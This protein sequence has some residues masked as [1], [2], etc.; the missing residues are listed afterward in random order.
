MNDHSHA[1]NG[2]S[3]AAP[4]VV[5]LTRGAMTESRHRVAAA[6]ADASGAVLLAA[7]DPERPIYARS[8]IKPLQA[9]AMVETG[10]TEAFGLGDAEIALACA[11][12]SGEPAHV[13]TVRAWLARIGRGEEDLECGA[14]PPLHLDSADSLVQSGTGPSPMH[15]NCSGKHCGFL[16]AAHHLGYDSKGYVGYQHPV[17]Q[18]VLGILEQMTGLDLGAAPRGTDGC[19]IPVIGIPLGNVALAMAR[20]ADPSDQPDHRQEAAARI[21]SAMIAE[22]HM[23]AGTGR[24]DTRV[25]RAMDGKAVVKGGAEGVHCAA[26]PGAGVGICVKAEDGAKR[27]AEAV[28]AH[29]LD[30]FG[31]LEEKSANDIGD[32]LAPIIY[33]HAGAEV[34]RIRVAADE[35]QG[36]EAT[37]RP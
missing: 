19:G 15:N 6:V 9:L 3:R 29:L 12:H 14:H 2:G 5:E 24:F 22:P 35:H 4:F 31:V 18:R 32:L 10:A 11:S 21:C 28:M 20:L 37:S 7:G 33:N 34:G 17:Q 26:I 8:A 1:P 13:D 25:I 27:A 30:R 16:T 36:V 23:V